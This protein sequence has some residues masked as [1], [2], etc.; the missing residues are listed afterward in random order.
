[1][2]DPVAIEPDVAD[3]HGKAWKVDLAA[4]RAKLD[5]RPEDDGTV[6]VWIVEAPWAHMIWHSYAVILLHLRPLPDASTTKIYLDGAT[7]ELGVYALDPDGKREPLIRGAAGFGDAGAANFLTPLNFAAQFVEPSDAAASERI[8]KTVRAICAGKL[9]PDTDFI[10]TW[11]HLFGD[12]MIKPE[13][14]ASAGE[15][16]IGFGGVEIVI[17]AKPGPQDMH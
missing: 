11:M 15:T 6:A 10:R 1:M 7:H 2:T 3:V 4:F 14:R 5:V 13:Y 12:N 16:R 8:E 9:S 17:P